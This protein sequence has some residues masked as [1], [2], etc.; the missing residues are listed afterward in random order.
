M[1]MRRLLTLGPDHEPLWVQLYVSPVGDQWRA[2]IVADGVPQPGSD[3]VKGIGFYA[4]TPKEAERLARAYLET[5][6]PGKGPPG[7]RGTALLFARK[8]VLRGR[9]NQRA[10]APAAGGVP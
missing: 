8:G 1:S 2:V 10:D 4:D 3:E 9:E 7:W 5:A 6:E